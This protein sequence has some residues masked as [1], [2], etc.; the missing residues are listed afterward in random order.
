[1]N[2][3]TTLMT[4]CWPDWVTTFGAERRSVSLRCASM[5]R[6]IERSASPRNALK[7]M[8]WSFALLPSPEMW[9]P[10]VER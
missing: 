1:M 7:R 8:N 9:L 4:A 3:V 5:W 6:I 2:S 10:S